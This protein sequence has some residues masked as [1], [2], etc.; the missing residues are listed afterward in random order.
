MDS[1]QQD[2]FSDISEY[3]D[4]DDD[5]DRD[6]DYVL[7]SDSGSDLSECIPR[8]SSDQKKRSRIDQSSALPEMSQKKREISA[9]SGNC[10]DESTDGIQK[11]KR[12]SLINDDDISTE[13]YGQKK[14]QLFKKGEVKMGCKQVY[15]K[16]NYCTFCGTCIKSKIARH[17]LTV[18]RSEARVM[19]II[20][21][22]KR[23]KERLKKL[24]L[25]ANEGNFKHNTQ[26]LKS[27]NG[28]LVVA[29]R[30]SDNEHNPGDFLPCEYC[31]KFV[32]RRGMWSHSKYCKVR[33]SLSSDDADNDDAHAYNNPVRRGMHLLHSALLE[34]SE[35]LA[36]QMLNRMQNDDIKA[37]ILEDDLIKRYAALRVEGLGDAD[38]QKINDI[39][40]VSQGARTLGRLV[41]EARK[42]IP[43]VTM[44][45]L[46]TAQNFDLLVATTKS[47][48]VE[49]DTPVLTLP[50]LIGNLLGHIAQIKIGNAL[51]CS[52]D[53]R[54]N[55]ATKFQQLFVSEWNYRVNSGAV[56]KMNAM[57]RTQ[58]QTIPLTEDLIKLRNHI[59]DDMPGAIAELEK[60]KTAQTYTY[61][62]K[63]VVA[64]LLLFNKRRRAEVTDLKLSDYNM[65]PDWRKDTNQEIEKAL[66]PIERSCARR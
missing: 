54:C 61:L 66:S 49:K 59:I 4:I 35:K 43:F 36:G 9:S 55:E 1:I 41:R 39:H 26:V 12:S 38:V 50:R 34:N 52:D 14:V 7:G 56:K 53:G 64:R 60:S 40:R 6:I 29:R 28:F 45:K 65:R 16:Q 57:K 31:R 32:L 2:L 37:I 5:V 13:E 20:C 25:L 23:S 19:D 51:R 3:S 8:I 44:D 42:K 62:A 46:I 30:N 21:L 11:K 27:G 10:S 18:H 33:Y 15:D 17:L 24:E 58:V 47:M 22:P 48:S 63:L